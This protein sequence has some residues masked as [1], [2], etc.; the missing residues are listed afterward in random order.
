MSVTDSERLSISE[1]ASLAAPSDKKEAE[2]AY[3]SY[4][5]SGQVDSIKEAQ[6][7]FLGVG[8]FK[9][10]AQFFGGMNGPQ[11]FQRDPSWS[12]LDDRGRLKTAAKPKTPSPVPPVQYI[13]RSEARKIAPLE[14][15]AGRWSPDAWAWC[16]GQP[17]SEAAKEKPPEPPTKYITAKKVEQLLEFKGKA[18]RLKESDGD[19][20]GVVELLKQHK[21]HGFPEGTKNPNGQG[22]DAA[23]VR[24]H[25]AANFEEAGFSQGRAAPL[26][27][28]EL[29]PTAVK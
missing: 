10:T 29:F 9:L 11:P 16:G 1:L 5:N 18:Y 17:E 3:L 20:H 22:F 13:T 7:P 28:G 26:Q 19:G 15:A 2:A 6:L 23:K 12:L 8:R 21:Y 24:A 4:I 27:K 25:L 14:H